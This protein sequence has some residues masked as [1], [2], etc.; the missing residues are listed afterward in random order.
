MRC[1]GGPSL[2]RGKEV[3]EVVSGARDAPQRR[4]FPSE[5]IVGVFLLL[6]CRRGRDPSFQVLLD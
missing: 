2:L 6:L 4:C 1:W 5:E 3:E